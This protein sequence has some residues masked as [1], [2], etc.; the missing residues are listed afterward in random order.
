MRSSKVSIITRTKNRP[1]FLA[2]AIS[3]VDNQSYESY[4]HIVINDGGDVEQV[5]NVI[6]GSKN[7]RRQVIHNPES[8]GLVNALNHAIRESRGEYI[9]VLDDDDYWDSELLRLA[10]DTVDK[11]GSRAVTFPVDIVEES[12]GSGKISAH[13]QYHHPYS[14]WSGEITLYKQITLNYL[15]TGFILFERELYDE[16]GGYDGTIIPGEDWDFGIRLLSLCDVD[17]VYSDE[18]LMFYS[19][20]YGDSNYANG[21][22]DFRQKERAISLLRNKY[23]RKDLMEGALGIGYIMNSAEYD[24]LNIIRLEAHVNNV[25]KGAVDSCVARNNSKISLYRRAG[26]KLKKYIRK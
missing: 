5:E 15:T 24:L 16:L 8:E 21:T 3:T 7:L 14:T 12:V 18:S 4:E 22:A 10:I 20:R 26:R 2:R 19:K 1:I 13:K 17:R 25:A 6:G 23:M 11:Y 9:I